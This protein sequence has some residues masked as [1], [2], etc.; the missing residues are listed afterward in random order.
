MEVSRLFGSVTF[1]ST[2]SESYLFDVDQTDTLYTVLVESPDVSISL[3]V[4]NKTTVGFDV[5]TDVPFTGGV[6]FTV[7]RDL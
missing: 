1:A 5:E 2:L 4:T 3:A 7:S 6:R